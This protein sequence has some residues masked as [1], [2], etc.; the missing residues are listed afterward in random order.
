M[1]VSVL[2]LTLGFVAVAALLLNLN[3][4]TG[5]SAKVKS[6]AIVLVSVI[7]VLT[8]FGYQGITGW[9]TP[10][11]LP[12]RFRVHWLMVEDPEKLSGAPGAIYFWVRE[13]DEAGFPVG[14]PRAHRVAWSESAAQAAEAALASMDAGELL[15]GRL[16]RNAMAPEDDSDRPISEF[17]GDGGAPG[18]PQPGFEFSRVPPPALPPKSAP[19]LG[20]D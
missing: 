11:P 3:L 7:Y 1:T 17:A 10:E 13:L 5:H 6:A 8:W 20:G 18:S 2:L 12:E 16:S 19:D 15:N 4:A 9:A 14:P